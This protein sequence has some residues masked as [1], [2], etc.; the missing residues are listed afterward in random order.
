MAPR[1]FLLGNGQHTAP[2]LGGSGTFCRAP[3]SPPQAHAAPHPAFPCPG[4]ESSSPWP[5]HS[6]PVTVGNWGSE[7]LSR[8]RPQPRAAMP[9]HHPLT[10]ALPAISTQL[11]ASMAHALKGPPG[12]EAA[13]GAL[14]LPRGTFIHIWMGEIKSGGLWAAGLGGAAPGERPQ[15]RGVPLG[16]QA[17][18]HC[19][20][21]GPPGCQACRARR[22]PPGVQGSG[23]LCREGPPR[24]LFLLP[25]PRLHDQG[26][27][28]EHRR[29]P[30]QD[31]VQSHAPS[32]GKDTGLPWS[33]TSL[34]PC[35]QHQGGG[36]VSELTSHDSATPQSPSLV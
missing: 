11:V 20:G 22:G 29:S 25:V 19:A 13:V 3:H 36:S 2:G 9:A 8:V 6:M 16:V 32:Q 35:P 18:A 23:P 5:A 28:P 24:V 1:P 10:V 26:S 21:R 4:Q 12:V 30:Q 34:H 31:Q 7:L 14:G 33:P 27:P 15:Y 17:Q